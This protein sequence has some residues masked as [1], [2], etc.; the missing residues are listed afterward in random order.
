MSTRTYDD[1]SVSGSLYVE[2]LVRRTMDRSNRSAS[3]DYES[4]CRNV[5][6]LAMLLPSWKHQELDGRRS[7]FETTEPTYKYSM[8]CGFKVG[9]PENPKKN[10]HGEIISPILADETTTDYYAMY[11]IILS[12]FED[13]GLLFKRRNT[14]RAKKKIPTAQ[15]PRTPIFEPDVVA[16]AEAEDEIE[17]EESGDEAKS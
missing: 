11:R 9:T 15:I 13:V 16:E 8:N 2:D 10:K 4:F 12:M 14:L 17:D 6:I 7:E 1:G 3:V 5:E